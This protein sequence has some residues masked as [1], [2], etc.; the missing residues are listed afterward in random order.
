[1]KQ[2]IAK[3]LYEDLRR[4]TVYG[5]V[6]VPSG[7]TYSSIFAWDSGWNYFWLKNLSEEAAAAELM[8]LFRTAE[9]DG[10][11]PH[12]TVY[13]KKS[14]YSPL[15]RLQLRLLRD[16][17][18]SS[19]TSVFIDPPVYLWAAAD[20]LE[21]AKG[22][23]EAD[24][25]F[26]RTAADKKIAWIKRSRTIPSLPAPFDRLPV[27]LHPLESGTDLS[28]SFDRIY[29]GLPGLL[30]SMLTIQNG[31]KE[32]DWALS[33][34]IPKRPARLVFDLTF[35]SFYLLSL[36][37]FEGLD[38]ELKGDFFESFY[39]PET[40]AFESWYI[41]RGRLRRTANPT[42]S[43]MLPFL[44]DITD[45]GTAKRAVARHCLPGG[46][47][48]RGKLPCFNNA[49]KSRKSPHLWRGS[50]SWMNMN[51]CH[52]LLLNKYG[53]IEEAAKL[54]AAVREIVSESSLPEYFNAFSLEP[55]GASG[56]SW[57]GLADSMV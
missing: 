8:T 39:N 57:N 5:P 14:R 27:L 33:G 29:R 1:M 44:A 37:K 17:F 54:S 30:L 38:D 18:D 3:R 35:L 32:E 34:S 47:F 20:L 10:K 13:E 36:Q 25:H 9:E 4:E 12:E 24:T 49:E 41:D 51:Y 21:T 53:Y 40:K 7:G 42:F 19:G 15:R 52:Y 46:T 28:P 6:I 48:W 43:S 11:I 31:M 23:S 26:I 56:F 16:T 50:C 2:N 45:N 22:L 55:G